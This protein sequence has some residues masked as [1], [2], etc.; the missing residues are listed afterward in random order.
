[1]VAKGEFS[2]AAGIFLKATEINPKSPT[3]LFYLGYS[4][5]KLNYNKAAVTALNQAHTLAP[6]S[7]EVL[8]ALG[9]AERTE[10]KFADAEKHLLKAKRLT[11]VNIPDIHWELAQLYGLNLKKYKEAVG[12]LE[13]YLKAGKYD[14]EHIKKIKRLITDFQEKAKNQVSK[15]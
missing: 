14:D 9:I 10:G 8:L 13:Q 3:T 1:M 5:N 4:L 15:N 6:A 2:E 12:E 7:M 11:K